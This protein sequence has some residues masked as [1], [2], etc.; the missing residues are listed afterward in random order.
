MAKKFLSGVDLANN[1]AINVADPTSAQD[2]STKN[3]T[4]KVRPFSVTVAR[5]GIADY[6]CD[7]TA[8]DVEL[9]AAIN[10]VNSAGGGVVFVRANT[11]PYRLAAV[12]TL[13]ENVSI[14][15]ER[16]ARQSAGGV[17]F[18]TATSFSPTSLFTMTGTTNPATNA[19]LKHDVHIENITVDGNSTTT[20]A[21]MLTNQDTIK[22]INCRF[23]NSTNAINTT[24]DGTSA[25]GA[26]TI[27]GGIYLERCNISTIG[28]GIGVILNY[29]TQCWINNCW[30][31]AGSG[32]P[33]AWIEFNASNKIKVTNCEF[34]TATTALSFT[35][36]NLGGGLDFPTH[37]ITV[38][39]SVF[40]TGATVI[41]DTRT[42]A[43][44]DYVAING[45][46][47][48]GT[49]MGST[50]VGTHNLVTLTDGIRTGTGAFSGDVTVP[51]EVYGIA[52]NGS[53]EVPT[54]N[55]LYDKIESI[56]GGGTG[57]VVGPASATDNGIVRFDATTGKLMQNTSGPVM[58][59]D[60]RISTVTDPTGA[61]D[62]ATKN[63]V[64]KN[65]RLVFNIKNYGAV[66]D[67][68]TDDTSAIQSALT[69]AGS[70]K[71]A[72]YIPYSTTPYLADPAT[73]LSVPSDIEIF[74]DGAGSVIK[75]PN[76]T[77]ASGN[78]LRIESKTNVHLRDF[79]LD[80]NKAN[81]ASG[82]NYG[83]YFAS[84]TDSAATNITTKNFTGVGNHV[85][86]CDRVVINKCISTGNT[87]HGFE[88][89]QARGCIWDAVRGYSNDRHGIF[90]SPGEVSGTGCTGNSFVNSTFTSNTQYGIAAGEDAGGLSAF[91]STDNV[92]ANNIVRDNTEYGINLY[93]V[94]GFTVTGNE[95][96]NNG[97][98]GVYIFE[99]RKHQIVGN[100][101]HNNGA[102]TNNTYDEIMIEGNTSGRA[103]QYNIVA[104]N[105]IRIEGTNKARYAINE[106]DSG[107]GPNII[108][109]NV[110]PA[111]GVTGTYNIQS[112]NTAISDPIGIWKET[113]SGK[114]GIDNA[115]G[116]MRLYS[117]LS[118]SVIQIV[119]TGATTEFW[120][121]G[122][123][124]AEFNATDLDLQSHN[125]TNLADPTS[126]QHAATK[127]YADTASTIYHPSGTDV[128]VADGGTGASTA[129]AARTN[130]GLVIGTDVQAHDADLDTWATKTAPSGTVLGTSDIQTISGAKTYN[131]GTLLDKGEIVFDVKAFG[132]VGND[133]TDDTTA[134]QNAI[135]AANSAGGGRVWFPKGTYKLTAA[136]KLYSG[137]TPT[138]AAYQNIILD[139]AGSSTTNGAILKQYTTG[140]D[141]IK[142]LNDAANSAQALNIGIKNLAL[143]WGTG[144]ATN[145]GNGLYLAQQATGGPSFQQFIIENVVA[146]GFGGSGKYGFNFESLITSKVDTCM[147]VI[148]ANGFFLNGG[149]FGAWSSVNTS[150]TMLN[151]YA[152][153]NTGTGY[154]IDHSTYTSLNSCAADSNGTGY[155]LNSANSISLVSCGAE[156]GN[157]DGASPGDAFKIA[158]SSAS[159][160]LYDCYSFQNYHYSLW[161][162][163][164]SVSVV[165]IG[166]QENSPVS[167]TNS[168]KI[169]S[170]SVVTL[171]DPTYTTATSVAGILSYLGDGGG[172][173]A[174]KEIYS[175]RITKRVGSTTSSATP[176][177]N[178][179]NVDMYRIT[180]QAAAITSFTTNL[181]GTP[182]DNQTLW[183]SI[184]DNGTARAITWGASFEASTVA[185]PTTTVI[186][187]RLDVG[188]VWN[189][190][191]SKWRCVAVA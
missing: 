117:N 151:C 113:P 50:L 180:A 142:G 172:G 97:K 42:H 15:G 177:I 62:A 125:I 57:D 72:V 3:Y 115:F 159:I 173:I 160:G 106:A 141:V 157:P 112:A 30:F 21:F 44:S 45:T 121:S 12:V 71:G 20:N 144:T 83:L 98:F 101:L 123:K 65:T 14:I 99:G 181:S 122:T 82:T 102:T 150:V 85:Y 128:A 70:A 77:N 152:N 16:M 190:V 38:T 29:Q 155:L 47:A 69:A 39:G 75:V 148:C 189:T 46:M 100:M 53:L 67:G 191:T 13:P 61:Q 89:E 168:F 26:G 175:T 63:Y 170:G 165:A 109:H 153:G 9:Q 74:G 10:A 78:L 183:I 91:L 22:F 140:A 135:D 40:A 27:P 185:L 52:W 178:T 162:T 107:D 110:V 86:D 93:K 156:Y 132:A 94:D 120:N 51:D 6:V 5:S 139:G 119:S 35:D 36:V 59:D 104:Y 87:Y 164:S 48:S 64:D 31:T 188:F 184:T 1:K 114:A 41:T 90:I 134:I 124:I 182:N 126:A 130:L 138:I 169:D 143:V 25:P 171:I 154:N 176:T 68:T 76:S 34:N 73:G 24:W 166:F 49:S 37:N 137:T 136:L 54:K 146:S 149:A 111:A 179:D 103:S 131:A 33:A 167:A 7:G 79:V 129:S 108:V 127:N 58:P 187:T 163:G 4:D 11:N 32:T 174:A 80:G 105:V 186:S 56:A 18:K 88:A 60:G 133:S 23:I 96:A 116:I 2:A 145:S 118:S 95:V 84:T 66:G 161:V 19:D 17:T 55:A 43:N 92:I 8:D 81:Q 28:T 147:S 158:G